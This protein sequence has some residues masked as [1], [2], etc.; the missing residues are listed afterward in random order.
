MC[1]SICSCRGG[2]D[3]EAKQGGAGDMTAIYPMPS[4][5]SSGT[6]LA[7]RMLSQLQAAEKRLLRVEQ[8]LT[9]GRRIQLSGEDPG[10]A[11]RAVALQR[12]LELKE[13]F[14]VNTSMSR[15]YLNATDTA[16]SGVANLLADVR[17]AAVQAAN[18]T[19]TES[20]RAALADRVQAAIDRML[21]VGNGS[22]RGRYLF[23]GSSP[24]A[25]PFETRGDYVVYNG[26]DTV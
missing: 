17:G 11:N 14:Q 7:R 16:L 9:T 12:L 4:G 13:Q 15:S 2:G 5:R 3:R 10:A 26:N 25:Q 24:S 1:W 19:L 23:A 22:F 20:E 6:L 8:Q 18:N 21:T